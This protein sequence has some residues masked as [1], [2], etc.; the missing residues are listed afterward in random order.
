MLQVVFFNT[1]L[2]IFAVGASLNLFKYE[3]MALKDHE[4]RALQMGYTES[5][6]RDEQ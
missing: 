4:K 2:G 5:L 1:L 3:T 6:V